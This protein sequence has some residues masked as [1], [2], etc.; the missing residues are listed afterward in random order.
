MTMKIMDAGGTLRTVS[1]MKVMDGGSL[2]NVRTVKIMDA[3]NTTLRTVAVFASS[4]SLAVTPDPAGDADYTNVQS[5]ALLAT[6]TGGLAPYTYSWSK[7]SGTTMNLSAPTSASTFISSPPMEI[8]QGVQ[9]VY[10]CTC[11]DNAGQVASDD[12]TVTF[13]FLEPPLIP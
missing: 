12:V 9:A 5:A 2:R 6:P 7:V 11:T 13:V 10:R 8:G 1:S 4:L 3:D